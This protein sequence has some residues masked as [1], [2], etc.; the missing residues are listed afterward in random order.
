MSKPQLPFPFLPAE[1]QENPFFYMP[2]MQV[3]QPQPEVSTPAVVSD[4][5][6]KKKYKRAWNKSQVEELYA[7]TKE[8]CC[9]NMKSLDD[10]K[11]SD[12]EIIASYTSQT[13]RKCMSKILE[14]KTSGTLRAGVWSAAEDEL[15]LQLLSA[16]KKKWGV[17]AEDLNIKIHRGLKL[18]TGKHCKE[19]WNNHLNPEIKRGP[20]T[21]L[22][23]IHLLQAHK[24]LGNRW[25]HIAKLI[26]F[27]TESSIKNRVK[28]L[29]NKEK[30]ELNNF[31]NPQ[32]ILDQLIMKKKLEIANTVNMPTSESAS[33]P[34]GAN[35]GVH[36]TKKPSFTFM[37]ME[38]CRDMNFQ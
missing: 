38:A 7:F 16:G 30:Q 31:D 2:W 4:L 17:I 1:S 15:L 10:L 5:E 19:R 28:S 33:P 21:L 11:F 36:P 12:F 13:A 34:S 23:D 14:I 29:I 3:M 32:V 26:A 35:Y 22:E 24:N 27:R 18:R 8:Y 6:N 9:K 20:W 37:A 25:S